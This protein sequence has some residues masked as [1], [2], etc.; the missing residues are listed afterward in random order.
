LRD[1]KHIRLLQLNIGFNADPHIADSRNTTPSH[2]AQ[3]IAHNVPWIAQIAFS[4]PLTFYNQYW[5]T[6]TIDRS[7][8]KSDGEGANCLA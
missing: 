8:G 3:R 7:L 5:F 2:W 1:F 6:F 4:T